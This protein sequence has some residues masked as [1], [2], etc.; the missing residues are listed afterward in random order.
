[1]NELNF[2]GLALGVVLS[3]FFAMSSTY[4]GLYAGMTISASVPAA[5]LSVVFLRRATI[6]EHNIVQTT[7]SAGESLAAGIIFTMPALL[8]S[9]AMV[10]LPWYLVTAV[11]LLGG[12]LG[13]VAMIWIRRPLIVERDKELTYPEGR[14]CARMLQLFMSTGASIKPLLAFIGVGAA[15]K[16]LNGLLGV[17]R[18]TAVLATGTVK[19]KSLTL[20][21]G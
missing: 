10:A 4:V 5:V 1:M 8:V 21:S 3:L 16:L 9:K 13:I 20:V 14:A 15:M 19:G 17:L 12:I 6:L 7:A 18:E 11:G 2:R